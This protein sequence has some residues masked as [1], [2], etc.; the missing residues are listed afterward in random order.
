MLCEGLTV[1]LKTLPPVWVSCT[2][3]AIALLVPCVLVT[4]ACR[5]ELAVAVTV[6]AA[7]RAL[8][9]VCESVYVAFSAELV[10]CTGETVARR[11]ESVAAV[12][13]RQSGARRS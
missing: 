2:G 10:T 3:S 1:A 11:S 5:T 6:N 13:Y 12:A 7:D 8:L 9:A 4:E